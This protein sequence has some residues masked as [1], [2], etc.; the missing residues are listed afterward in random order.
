MNLSGSL[1][2][3]GLFSSLTFSVL[4]VGIAKSQ[5]TGKK[6]ILSPNAQP[7]WSLFAGDPSRK[8]SVSRR[9]GRDRSKEQSTDGECVD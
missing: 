4:P 3:A 2:A 7:D 9:A 1:I 5:D 6:V 8:D